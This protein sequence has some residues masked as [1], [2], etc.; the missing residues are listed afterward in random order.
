[1][2][3]PVSNEKICAA[4]L[5]GAFANECVRSLEAC[6]AWGPKSGKAEKADSYDPGEPGVKKCRELIGACLEA[7]GPPFLL[8]LGESYIAFTDRMSCIRAA[9][10]IS[11]VRADDDAWISD[12]EKRFERTLYDAGIREFEN[13]GGTIRRDVAF[14]FEDER[15]RKK[16]RFVEV[17]L[18]YS[19]EPLGEGRFRLRYA[20][21]DGRG[22]SLCKGEEIEFTRREGRIVEELAFGLTLSEKADFR[23]VSSIKIV[24]L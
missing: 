22:I 5:D 10:A 19:V 9:T 16:T 7:K 3:E 6:E 17:K 24:R 1:M 11:G 2:S 21:E 23:K 18:S 13:G 8:P 20:I 14:S 12:G 4:A 15:G